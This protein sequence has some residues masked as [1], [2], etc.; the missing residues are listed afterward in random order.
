[1]AG[2]KLKTTAI[3]TISLD[4]M[5]GTDSATV[6]IDFEN[7]PKT[8]VPELDGLVAVNFKITSTSGEEDGLSVDAYPR[9]LYDN[10][11]TTCANKLDIVDDLSWTDGDIYK[12]AIQDLN[13]RALSL[14]P[15]FGYTLDFSLTASGQ[16]D[17]EVWLTYI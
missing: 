6:D 16:A 2:N 15:A 4:S 1:M 14:G 13:D 11:L 12:Y 9:D 5:S 8:G 10:T 17:I 7:N 3:Q